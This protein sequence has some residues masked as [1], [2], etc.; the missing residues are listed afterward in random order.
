[1]E[2]ENEDQAIVPMVDTLLYD[3]RVCLRFSWNQG[4]ILL[5]DNSS[6]MHTRTAFPGGSERELWRIH[7]DEMEVDI[8]NLEGGS[9]DKK[10]GGAVDGA[11]KGAQES[12]P[13]SSQVKKLE[14][15]LE[16][17]KAKLVR[18]TPGVDA[19]ADGRAQKRVK[20]NGTGH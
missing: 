5:A 7:L 6:M 10:A 15:E 17:T 20:V 11:K 2:I 14:D 18:A 3:R 4:D 19:E 13:V 12:P 16:D 1:M 8:G 9:V